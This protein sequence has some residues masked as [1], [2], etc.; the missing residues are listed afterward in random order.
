M[1]RRAGIITASGG[2]VRTAGPRRGQ[3]MVESALVIL[4]ACFLFLALFQYA[5][6]FADKAVLSHAAARAARARAVG[7]N[8][9]MVRKSAL[10]GA[11][12]ASGRRLVPDFRETDAARR[13]AAGRKN[14]LDAFLDLAFRTPARTAGY[15]IEAGRVPDFMASVSSGRARGILD[16]ERWDD[17]DVDIRERSGFDEESPA[18]LT[19]RVRQR[20]RLPIGR[21]ALEAGA[22]DSAGGRDAGEPLSLAGEFSIESHYP[23]YLEDA[24]W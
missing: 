10:A 15:G 23:L 17:T 5:R 14:A 19:V 12:P 6:L 1:R 9:W 21:D 20:R 2:A 13:P 24:G 4:A 7:F 3:A 22:F 8:E 11:I 18:S 16:Y